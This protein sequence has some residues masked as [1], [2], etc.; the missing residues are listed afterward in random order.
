MKITK[1]E[2][3]ILTGLCEGKSNT[4]ISTEL[5]TSSKTV[6]NQVRTLLMKTNAGNRTRLAVLYA[7]NKLDQYIA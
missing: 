3:Q 7:T 1:R 4:E 6:E 2:T 5:G